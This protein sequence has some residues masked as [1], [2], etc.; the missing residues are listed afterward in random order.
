M[1]ILSVTELSDGRRA[2]DA[3]TSVDAC[4]HRERKAAI[5]AAARC[6]TPSVPWIVDARLACDAFVV[7]M[8][9][10]QVV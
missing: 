2:D 3:Y 1:P 6:V 8:H 4:T 9:R 7:H 10:R 5:G